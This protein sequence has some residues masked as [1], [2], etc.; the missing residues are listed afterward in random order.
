HELQASRYVFDVVLADARVQGADAPRTLVAAI[1]KLGRASVD[2]IAIVRGGGSRT[3]LVAFDHPDVARA[4]AG[5]A[6]PVF[7]GVGH[8][9]DRSV[10]DE[11][12]HSAFKT[13]TAV[14]GALIAAVADAEAELEGFAV[15]LG[16][17]T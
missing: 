8:E 16:A 11:V 7:T 3:D 6:V 9:I 5:A 17:S 13:P 14:A 15:R 4:I 2:V 12:A 10:A 1:D